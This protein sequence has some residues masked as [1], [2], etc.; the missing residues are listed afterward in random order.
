M[1]G[2]HSSLKVDE[3]CQKTSAL[4]PQE[5]LRSE[6]CRWLDIGAGF[7]ELLEALDVLVAS[8]SELL[9]LE[10]CEAKVKWCQSRGIPVT[11]AELRDISGEFTHVS[12]VNVFSHLPDPVEF[13]EGLR[14]RLKPRGQLLLATGNAGDIPRS[15]FPGSLYLPDHLSFSGEGHMRAI[16]DKAG[17]KVIAMQ[18]YRAG[19][20][21]ENR[22]VGH[23]KN[24]AR[25]SLRR[26]A[27][28]LRIDE[29][30]R[31]RF[32]WIRAERCA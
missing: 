28:P 13:F 22:L 11:S 8:G 14:I 25:K 29:N 3:F 16:L 27:V 24:L 15:E 12:L 1:V 5:E 32:L 2:R 4:F 7:G 17:Y 10:P 21:G 9:G 23:L 6:P 19:V 18:R 30:S 31:F 20:T 26:P